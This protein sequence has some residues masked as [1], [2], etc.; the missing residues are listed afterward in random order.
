LDE[1]SN[2]GY[3]TSYADSP[4]FHP[5]LKDFLLAKLGNDRVTDQV[6]FELVEHYV[7]RAEWDNAF[8]IIARRPKPEML[9][10]L[11]EFANEPLLR[12]GRTVTLKEWVTTA[13]QLGARDAVLDLVM[14]ELAAREGRALEAERSAIFA[15]RDP[16]SK[17]QFRAFCLAGRAAH[18]DSR[19]LAALKHFRA[20]EAL[21][22][23]D[24]ELQEARWG[25]LMCATGLDDAGELQRALDDFLAYEPRTA[26]DL[27][28][29]ANAKLSTSPIL[30]DSARAANEGLAVM[31]L[32][33]DANPVI[34]VSFLN[35]LGRMLSLFGRYSEALA[36]AERAAALVNDKSLAFAHPHVHLAKAIALLGLGS[37]DLASQELEA[38]ERVAVRIHD[39]HN[40]VDVRTVRARVSLSRRD[41]TEAL[42]LTR[43]SA[44]GVTRPM[45]AELLATRG[46]AFMCAGETAESESILKQLRHLDSLPEAAGLALAAQAVQAARMKDEDGLLAK[47]KRLRTL[48][49]ADALVVA[50]RASR[51]LDAALKSLE[52]SGVRFLEGEAPVLREE[53]A[54][55]S[56]T[57]RE[58]EVLRLLGRGHTNKEIAAK[59]VIAEVTAKVHVRNILRKLQAR[60]RTEAAILATKIG[61]EGASSRFED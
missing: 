45:E 30:G 38:A 22:A 28:R 44:H 37:F 39:R 54:L 56:L 18:L 46:L 25:A 17:H 50:R 32:V 2:A 3:F 12:E 40:I 8:H 36:I 29:A 23:D 26:D 19:E 6:I 11:I 59:L 52:T 27:L 13:A 10:S 16:H 60:S 49:V 15:A 55:A 57:R 4:S 53:T 31:R 61:I 14:A 20:A 24:Q 1:A 21:A 42:E 43:A 47:L 58:L 9:V 34:A 51:D 33:G 41:F 48:G 5:L 35:A 7:S